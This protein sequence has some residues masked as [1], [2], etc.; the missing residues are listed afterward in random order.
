MFFQKHNRVYAARVVTPRDAEAVQRLMAGA[1]RVFLRIPP[2]QVLLRLSSGLSWVA[3]EGDGVGGFML[4]EK[5]PFSIAIIACLC[6]AVSNPAPIHIPTFINST[7]FR[8]SGP[9]SAH[10]LVSFSCAPHTLGYVSLIFL[11]V[12]GRSFLLMVTSYSN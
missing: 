9:A 3:G 2:E 7:V 1:W 10:A 6:V 12:F 4:A 11:K 5:Q 8:S